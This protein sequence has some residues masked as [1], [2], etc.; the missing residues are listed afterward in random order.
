MNFARARIENCLDQIYLILKRDP[1]NIMYL[2]LQIRSLTE[3]ASEKIQLGQEDLTLKETCPRV[4]NL[5][6][7]GRTMTPR[8]RRS[9]R[10]GKLKS[11]MLPLKLNFSTVTAMTRYYYV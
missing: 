1:W 4:M 3:L 7:I 11:F 8:P 2:V 6:S 10:L 9:L 5:T